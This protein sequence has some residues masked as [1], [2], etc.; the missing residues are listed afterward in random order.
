MKSKKV[1]YPFR[2]GELRLPDTVSGF[3][4]SVEVLLE[5][6]VLQ[7]HGPS[8]RTHQ[9]LSFH[10]L[11]GDPVRSGTSFSFLRHE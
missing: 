6:W 8:L 2:V 4:L 11:F 9:L 1:L 10:L 3:I 7:D 5:F